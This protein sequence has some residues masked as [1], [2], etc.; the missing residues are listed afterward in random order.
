MK[1]V[2]PPPAFAGKSWIKN[3]GDPQPRSANEWASDLSAPQFSP[4][5]TAHLQ[6]KTQRT[7]AHTWTLASAF[8]SDHL[9]LH[10]GEKLPR[11]KGHT[12]PSLFA[13][14]LNGSLPFP[15][16]FF[17]PLRMSL[18]DP[19]LPDGAITAPAAGRL[20][21]GFKIKTQINSIPL[22]KQL[23]NR[24]LVFFYFLQDVWHRTYKIKASWALGR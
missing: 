7:T 4:H 12:H 24:L 11:K 22:L 6:Q 8:N 1:A 9:A 17:F 14:Q 19:C 21:S 16:F 23:R 18:T 15:F 3:L 10:L 20:E 5:E 13:C 2:S